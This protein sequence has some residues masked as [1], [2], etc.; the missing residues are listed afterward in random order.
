MEIGIIG[1]GQMGQF[2]ARHLKAAHHVAAADRTDRSVQAK[3]E[4]ID[5]VSLHEAASKDIVL[6][7]VPTSELRTVLAAIQ[8][9]LGKDA[10]VIDVCSVKVL[11][12]SLM[13]EMLP[14]NDVIGTHPL[15]GPQSG[16]NG[17]LGLKIVVCP[18]R[19][20]NE[21]VEKVKAIFIT[22]GLQILEATPEEHD[23]AMATA[24]ALMHFMAKGMM[25]T[26]LQDNQ[27]KISAL[28]KA[29]EL[30]DIFRDDSEQLFRDV[31][32]FN[33]YAKD[34]RNRFIKEL[35]EIDSTLQ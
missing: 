23:K 16:R 35:Q 31:Q 3:E 27:I 1:F 19:A 5:F 28:D 15:F 32:N 33:P 11:P 24:H 25:H 22:L 7:A 29:L 34:M 6:L 10:I 8:P 30:M 9:A 2:L 12:C 26:G 4:G 18:A 13:K 14:H 21:S 17:I 20:S